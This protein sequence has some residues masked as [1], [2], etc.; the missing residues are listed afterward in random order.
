[1]KSEARISISNNVSLHALGNFLGQNEFFPDSPG[2]FIVKFHPKF[3]Y[4]QPFALAMLAAW[5]AYWKERGVPMHCENIGSLGVAY[6]ARMKLF[7]LPHFLW[8][9]EI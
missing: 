7:D 2:S 4:L 6:A 1:M 9:V 8:T 5:G 3:V